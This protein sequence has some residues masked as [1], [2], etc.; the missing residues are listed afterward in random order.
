MG[1]LRRGKK[2]AQDPAE[3]VESATA[4]RNGP[5]SLED[6]LNAA[7][8]IPS[9]K[10][11]HYVDGLRAKHPD[12]GP[13]ELL[14]ILERR[15][16]LAV[17]TS[18]GA[19]GAAAA[20]PAIGTGVALALTSGQVASFLAASGVLAMAVAD[21]HGIDVDDVPRRRAVLLTALLG[22]KGPQLLEQQIGVS[23]VTWGRTLMT[24]VPLGTVKAVNRTLRKRVVAGSAAKAG[25][26]MLGRL[27]PFGVG[28]A[29]GYAGGKVMGGSMIR[30]IRGAFGP[31]PAQFSREVAGTFTVI[32]DSVLAQIES[33]ERGHG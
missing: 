31:A 20:V 8:T 10:V 33:A 17:K 3:Q 6:V 19:V 26:I 21:V 12:A 27:L 18:G 24:R 32:E 11:H 5:R 29:I 22:E 30:G 13:E 7:V 25:S 16:L 28:A 1:I 23:T 15:Y 4:S 9:A 14:Q 2:S